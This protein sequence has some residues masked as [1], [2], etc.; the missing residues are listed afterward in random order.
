MI[1]TFLFGYN[2]LDPFVSY[3]QNL[4][5]ANP[6]IKAPQCVSFSV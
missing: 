1:Y 6:T 4:A 5:V 2:I 3:I